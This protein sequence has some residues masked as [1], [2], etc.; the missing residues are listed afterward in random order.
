MERPSGITK[1]TERPSRGPLV[2]FR[3]PQQPLSAL[4]VGGF[5]KETYSTKESVYGP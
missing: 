5:L 2:A 4:N 1:S 3:S